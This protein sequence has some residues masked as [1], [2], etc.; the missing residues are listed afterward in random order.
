MKIIYENNKADR[1]YI[2]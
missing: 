1:N 2:K